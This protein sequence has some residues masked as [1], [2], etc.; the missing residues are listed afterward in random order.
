M[1][2]RAVLESP[3]SLVIEHAVEITLKWESKNLDF[4]LV[5]KLNFHMALSKSLNLSESIFLFLK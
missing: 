4:V 5:L 1:T 2:F 3:E